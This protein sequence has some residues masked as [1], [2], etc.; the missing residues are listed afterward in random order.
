M[1]LGEKSASDTD[2]HPQ[3]GPE[4]RRCTVLPLTSTDVAG[5]VVMSSMSC[6]LLSSPAALSSSSPPR[7]P[8]LLPRL[9]AVP[10]SSDIRL[11]AHVPVA[12]LRL[13]FLPSFVFSL[14][15]S[16]PSPRGEETLFH[17]QAATVAD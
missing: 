7:L 4:S 3:T 12:C 2:A 5:E 6:V 1:R 9:S 17:A 13:S 11:Y 14:L 15:P 16:F 10:L 8:H